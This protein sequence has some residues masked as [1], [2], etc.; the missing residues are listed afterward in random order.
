MAH[1]VAQNMAPFNVCA[2]YFNNS[3]VF[4][5]SM[6]LDNSYILSVSDSYGKD[7]G[8]GDDNSDDSVFEL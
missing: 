7:D 5:T 2:F 3:W 4:Q 1:N 8:H 6:A